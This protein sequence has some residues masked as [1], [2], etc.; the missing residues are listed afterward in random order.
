M[1]THYFGGRVLRNSMI[2]RGWDLA[3]YLGGW[4]TAHCP[5]GPRIVDE[6]HFIR[7]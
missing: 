2:K 3:R 6:T 4:R 5:R 1:V 7:R